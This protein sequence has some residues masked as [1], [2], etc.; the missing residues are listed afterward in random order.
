MAEASAQRRKRE[1]A[2]V[3]RIADFEEAVALRAAAEA[4]MAAAVSGLIDLGNTIAQAATLTEQT[5][6]EIRRLRKLAAQDTDSPGQTEATT[7][8]TVAA[9]REPGAANDGGRRAP[10][11]PARPSRA[12][13][14]QNTLA[15]DVTIQPEAPQ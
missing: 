7:E 12:G 5:E 2:E 4:D 11:R 10:T 15:F 13:D 14:E 9:A 8:V 6:S 1:Q 3:E